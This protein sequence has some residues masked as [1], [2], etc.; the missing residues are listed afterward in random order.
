MFDAFH[1]VATNAA[2]AIQ[3]HPLE[4]SQNRTSLPPRVVRRRE[5][6]PVR[7]GW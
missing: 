5:G 1:A 6:L 3:N 4:L 2:D 7:E